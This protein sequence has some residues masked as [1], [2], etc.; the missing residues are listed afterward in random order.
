MHFLMGR[1]CARLWRIAGGVGQ[2]FIGGLLREIP[3][4]T[5]VYV[6]NLFYFG[7]FQDEDETVQVRAGD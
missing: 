2:I 1:G 7:E 3:R 6:F 5:A 4:Q